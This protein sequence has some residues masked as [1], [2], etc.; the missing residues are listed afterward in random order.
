[1]Q[2]LCSYIILYKIYLLLKTLCDIQKKNR[3]ETEMRE[4]KKVHPLVQ[5]GVLCL[6]CIRYFYVLLK[7]EK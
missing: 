1:M 5:E 6:F 4:E 7:D 2:T 3:N